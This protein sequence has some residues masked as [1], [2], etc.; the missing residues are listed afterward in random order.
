MVSMTFGLM[1]SMLRAGYQAVDE[2]GLASSLLEFGAWEA[3]AMAGA[4][5]ARV[6][7]LAMARERVRADLLIV[8]YLL[9]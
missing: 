8:S 6:D 5:G 7:A 1:V 4:R 2:R 3:G 9:D